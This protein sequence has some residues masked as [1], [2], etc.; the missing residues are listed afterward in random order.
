MKLRTCRW[1]VWA[2]AG[3]VASQAGAETL[4]GNNP[5]VNNGGLTQAPG[6]WVKSGTG[7][8]AAD[9]D[10]HRTNPDDGH[11][12]NIAGSDGSGSSAP[13]DVTYAQTFT[14]APGVYIIHLSG[15]AKAWAGW[16]GGE[17]WNW[18]QEAHIVLLVDGEVVADMMSSNNTN[19]DTW[20]LWTY[21]QTH[22]VNG[23]IEV[24][25][26][27]VKGNDNYGQGGLGAI[28]FSSRFDD[29]TLEVTSTAQCAD[30]ST[31]AEVDPVNPAS[32]EF[33]VSGNP[34]TI[35][36]TGTNLAAVTGVRLSGPVTLD[37]ANVTASAGQVSAEF[38]LAA[39]PVGTYDVTVLRDAP[40]PNATRTDAFTIVPGKFANGGFEA[41]DPN[42]A[43]DMPGWAFLI[44]MAGPTMLKQSSAGGLF[45]GIGHPFEPTEEAPSVYA[46]GSYGGN[47]SFHVALAQ[48]FKTEPGV[49][50]TVSGGW[51]GGVVAEPPEGGT[52]GTAWWETLVVDGTTRNMNSAGT[53]IAKRERPAGGGYL[54]FRELFNGEF[55]AG[56]STTTIFLKW[57]HVGGSY[58]YHL[59]GWDALAI[60]PKCHSP[61][62][63]ADGD[64]DVDMADF[65]VFQQCF[66]GAGTPV[67]SPASTYR[68]SCFDRDGTPD[69]DVDVDDLARFVQCFTG[70]SV[71]FDIDHPPVGCTP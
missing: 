63:D 34:R 69:G 18:V 29:I 55:T 31:I 53:I 48:T 14:V 22:F 68:C 57:G 36:V 41:G 7:P 51:F 54:A 28:W 23:T 3:W 11:D 60:A 37:G 9:A 21:N 2:V 66:A 44:D 52:D 32:V 12:W 19:R 71:V 49:V 10:D 1:I 62:A 20:A 50:Y 4:I 61:F 39:A 42:N 64:H 65:A 8:D 25:L 17:N 47:G 24:R 43:G 6:V 15:W 26:R 13:F 30:P 16:W 58:A 27:A 45:S 67:A 33:A 70:P 5:D 59:A 56:D 35:A 46:G 40:C 38:D